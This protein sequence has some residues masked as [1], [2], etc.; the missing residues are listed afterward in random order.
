MKLDEILESNRAFTRARS[1]KP[2]PPVSVIRRAIVACYDP[3]LDDLIPACLGV[4]A[5]EAFVFRSAGALVRP[6][7]V[8]MR[9]LALAVFMFGVTEVIVLGHS[10]C[11]MAK[12]QSTEF[13]DVFRRRGVRR[14][15]FG[16]SDL[17]EW[18]GAI[19][20]PRRGVQA[21][22]TAIR[23]AAFMP[24]DL[25]TAGFVLDDESGAIEVVATPDQHT[26]TTGVVEA[27]RIAAERAAEHEVCAGDPPAAAPAIEGSR[28][29]GSV[30][31]LVEAA[32]GFVKALQT[33][34]DWRSDIRKL[35]HD[36]RRQSSPLEKLRQLEAFAR[37]RGTDSA[38][39]ARAFDQLRRASAGPRGAVDPDAIFKL[40]EGIAERA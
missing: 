25:E 36:L 4:A 14:E 1:P 3:R 9:S 23:G 27:D 13:V 19:P 28:A 16:D 5:G 29:H 34:V 12:F 8:T 40:I 35:Q 17:R 31:P 15:A 24:V 26:T 18:V 2:L 39:I 32:V 6:G 10:S 7:T 37:H 22:L 30:D 38:E 20:D 21:S 33:R 11:R